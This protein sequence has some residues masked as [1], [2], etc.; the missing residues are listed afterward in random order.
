MAFW[1]ALGP[2]KQGICCPG[3][4]ACRDYGFQGARLVCRQHWGLYRRAASI[5]E[6]KARLAPMR[7]VSLDFK[8]QA[9][10]GDNAPDGRGHVMGAISRTSSGVPKSQW[11]QSPLASLAFVVPS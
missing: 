6:I 3:S 7:R 5:V 2:D 11:C 10:D 4:E 9:A 8:G 1:G